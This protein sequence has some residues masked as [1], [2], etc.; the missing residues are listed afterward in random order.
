V[1]LTGGLGNQMFQYAAARAVA[2]RCGEPLALDLCWFA[3]PLASETPRHYALGN[4]C[5]DAEL[6]NEVQPRVR[7]ARARRWLE[8]RLRKEKLGMPIYWQKTFRYDPG[9]LDV[10]APAYLDGYFQ[11]ERYFVDCADAIFA[12]FQPRHAP[13]EKTRL[14]LDRIRG[15]QAICMHVRRGDYVSS[16]LASAQHGLC[17]I[18]YYER[19]LEIVVA[20]LDQPHCFV[21][22]DDP[23]W[24]RNNLALR[25]ATTVVDI[26]GPDEPQ[27]DLRLMAACHSY[28]IANSS[29]SWWGAW[30][31]RRE[32]K[33]VIAPARW[34]LKEGLDTSDLV[35]ED[36]IR[37]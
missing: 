34:F 25:C 11:S 3:N 6:L 23:A 18:D 4:F 24:V 26:H 10:R 12:D 8:K 37:A 20:K 28:V 7:F 16:R 15:T 19:G 22:S 1:R 21:F 2:L 9:I 36:W 5:L 31:G 30:L 32:G 13:G 29:L 17:P 33:Q 35:P 14:M 27:E